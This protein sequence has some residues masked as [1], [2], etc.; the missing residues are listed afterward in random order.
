MKPYI[1]NKLGI[2]V[3]T[4]NPSYLGIGGKRTMI[5]GQSSAKL[6]GH[7]MIKQTKSKRTAG[8][9]QVVEHLLRKW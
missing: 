5:Q 8:T 7:P 1:K 6:A 2:V 9:A 3:H 4:Y